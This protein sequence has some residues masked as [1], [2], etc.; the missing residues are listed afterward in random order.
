MGSWLFPP[1]DPREPL[2]FQVLDLE[3][4]GQPSG[5]LCHGSFQFTCWMRKERTK[6]II[7]QA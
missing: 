3:A 1:G 5:S 6:T 4:W 7:Q 2:S